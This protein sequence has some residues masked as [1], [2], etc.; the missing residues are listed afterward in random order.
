MKIIIQNAFLQ[1]FDCIKNKFNILPMTIIEAYESKDLNVAMPGVYVFWRNKEII[2][3]GRHF[4]NSRKR[5]IQHVTDNTKNEVFQM[6][7]LKNSTA[8]CGIILI[9]CKDPK[10]S[11]WVA[12]IEI[13]MERELNSVIKS[14]RTG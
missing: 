6:A 10:D 11:H 1:E 3:V 8:D 13:Y 7:S 12:A 4:V 5:A 9:N 14:K 2:K